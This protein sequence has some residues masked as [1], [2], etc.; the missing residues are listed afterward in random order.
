MNLTVQF[1]V[2]YT[3]LFICQTVRQFSG[4]GGPLTMIYILDGATK[5]VLFAPMLGILFLAC[6][7]RAL[8]LTRTVDNKVP[9]SAGPQP[10]AQEGMYWSTW[11]LLIQVVMA[12]LVPLALSGGQK[13]EVDDDGNVVPPAGNKTVATVLTVIRYLC[14]IFMYGGAISVMY[15][16]HTMSP[17]Q[18]PP[19][20]RENEPLVE[21]VPA[22]PPPPS[23]DTPGTATTTTT[24]EYK[25]AWGA[26]TNF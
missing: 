7:M 25:P 6:R 3:A 21:G 18:L 16:I 10:W 22:V 23:P 13:V 24:L 26:P 9:P 8:Q 1:F 2:V 20:V 4:G 14:L 19:Y 5:T 12:I 11:A 17:E 15:G